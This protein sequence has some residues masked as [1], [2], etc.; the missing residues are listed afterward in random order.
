[1]NINRMQIDRILNN[2]VVITLGENQQET[3]VMGKG[4]GFQKK[5]GESIN[6]QLIEKI[7][8][9]N[10][11]YSDHF[12]ALLEQVPASCISATEEIIALAKTRLATKLHA[13]VLIS[14][15][16]HLHYAL[17]RFAEN[18]TIPN[19]LLWEI[20][21]LYASEFAIGKESLQIIYRHTGVLLPED[22][23]GYIALHLVNAQLN[24]NMQ[25]TMKITRFMQDILSLVQYHFTLEYNED[26][27]S[28]Q[29]FI[30]HLKFFAQRIFD[31]KFVNNDDP[32]LPRLVREKYVASHECA[33]KIN[34]YIALHHD[35]ALTEDELMFLT[36]HIE[37][38]R[39]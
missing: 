1:M 17:Q 2:N 10:N 15:V 28:Y 31:R 8:S 22:E 29:R 14:L 30:T 38:L 35:H 32:S 33:E 20:K 7:F 25:N 12:K 26:S 36:I 5:P 19:A 23:A 13:S 18:I 16:D 34:K 11:P 39:K 37:Q 3:V 27:L 24:D 9:L 6:P 21:K 4:I